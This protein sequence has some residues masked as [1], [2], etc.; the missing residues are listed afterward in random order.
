LNSIRKRLTYANVMS[1]I[2]VFLLLGGATAIAAKQLGKKTVGTKQLKANAVTTAKL[3]NNSVTT[4]KLKDKAVTTAK[5]ADNAVTGP[6]V[7]VSTLGTVPNAT[8]AASANT[9]AGQGRKFVRANASGFVETAIKSREASP[10]LPLFTI[11][12]L[13]FYAKCFESAVGTTEGV[14]FIRTSE[15]GAAYTSNEDT[16]EGDPLL[17]TDTA[18]DEREILANS[19]PADSSSFYGTHTPLLAAFA[20]NGTAVVG[21]LQIAV[22]SGNLSEGNGVFGDGNV[23]LFS[24]LVTN[25]NG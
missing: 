7:Q 6:K 18:E 2:A 10:E 15:N 22:K 11:G 5:L 12:P 13:S 19:A 23:C 24:A 20:P 21:E 3:K 8:N 16:L 14:L 1:S 25:V 4:K 9:L 17:N